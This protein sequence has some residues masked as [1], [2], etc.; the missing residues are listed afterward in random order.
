MATTPQDAVPLPF[1]LDL[2]RALIGAIMVNNE[3]FGKVA[4]IV[5]PNSFF[6]Q[7]H[8]KMWT[9]IGQMINA[10][11]TA[12]PITLKSYL[13]D[14]DLG[15][16]ETPMQY[17]ARLAAEA[18]S[19]LNAPDYAADLRELHIRRRVMG[20]ADS[21]KA[22]SSELPP[23]MRITDLILDLSRDLDLLIPQAGGEA[24]NLTAFGKIDVGD[25]AQAHMDQRGVSGLSSGYARLD[26]L[27]NGLVAGNFIVLAGRPAMGKTA[28]ATGIA[29]NV[30]SRQLARRDLG[31]KPEPVA[32]FSIEMPADQLKK[33]IL[34]D[35]AGVAMRKLMRGE[36]Q[37]S[38]ME[39]F[40]IAEQELRTLPLYIDQTGEIT[41]AQLR[42]KA[43]RFKK[44]HGMSLLVIDYL[45]LMKGSNN[46]KNENRV[47]EVTEITVGLKALAKELKVPIIALSQL[48]RDLENRDDKRPVL[49]DLRESGSIEQDADTVIFVYREEY[50]LRQREP[51]EEGERYAEWKKQIQRWEGVA[52]IIAGKNRHGSVGSVELGWE[53][54][55]TRFTQEPPAKHIEPEEARRA[56]RRVV[57]TDDGKALKEIIHELATLYGR[58]PTAEEIDAGKGKIHKLA[59]VVDREEARR[60]FRERIVPDLE[61]AAQNRRIQKAADNLRL[62]K[63][64]NAYNDPDKKPFIYL[65]SMIPDE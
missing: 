25:V 40:H 8:Q 29:T 55:L 48:N 50:Y 20:I 15:N 16:G 41:I 23:D 9:V 58:R 3:A 21:A 51:K 60:L 32:F 28:L 14:A 26:D 63:Q 39:A 24:G 47:N 22:I 45:Q 35:R 18:T 36:A 65:I 42:Q 52:E 53:G 43:R 13:G 34:S 62:A 31:E 10:G 11:K 27:I 54:W 56:E 44:L 5:E 57:L 4:N 61:P 17:L 49:K 64:T 46:R 30:A 19:V 37:N 38:E 6:E 7:V 33:R 1:N 12:T 59:Q 2:E